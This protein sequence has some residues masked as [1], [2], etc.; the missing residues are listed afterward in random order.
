[1]RG[2]T[3]QAQGK[4]GDKKAAR[5]GA[6]KEGR[7]QESVQ[8]KVDIA[9]LRSLHRGWRLPPEGVAMPTSIPLA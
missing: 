4:A 2:C 3:V 9:M 1:M 8:E 5:K 7:G 6:P